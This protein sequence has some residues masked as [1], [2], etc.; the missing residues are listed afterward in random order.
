LANRRY[1]LILH[2]KRCLANLHRDDVSL[3]RVSFNSTLE[4][5]PLQLCSQPLT[6][7]S[8][9]MDHL[10]NLFLFPGLSILS[11]PL[12][13]EMMTTLDVWMEALVLVCSKLTPKLTLWS[14]THVLI[15]RC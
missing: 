1:H 9:A 15:W 6:T 5:L 3:L 11:L 14:Q 13:F 10:E 4:S 2:W 7:N 8:F 12:F